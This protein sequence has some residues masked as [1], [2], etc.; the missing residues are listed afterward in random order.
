MFFSDLQ[1]TSINN[2][3][4]N[5]GS[6]SRRWTEDLLVHALHH[7]FVVGVRGLMTMAISKHE[8]H[9]LNIFDTVIAETVMDEEATGITGQWFI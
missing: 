5:W 8:G 1:G 2:F 7:T 9:H 3:H 4:L 6:V